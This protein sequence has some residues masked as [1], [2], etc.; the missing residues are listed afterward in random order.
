MKEA[1]IEKSRLAIFE[2]LRILRLE[3][4]SVLKNGTFLRAW[5]PAGPY[6]FLAT[7]SFSAPAEGKQTHNLYILLFSFGGMKRVV[8]AVSLLLFMVPWVAAADVAP[9]DLVGKWSFEETTWS[10][11]GAVKDSAQSA[12]GTAFGG[13]RSQP[14]GKNGR[15]AYFDGD[16]D[17]VEIPT[18][19]A[20]NPSSGITVAGWFLVNQVPGASSGKSI[21]GT[22]ISKRDSYA[23][24]PNPD[25][26]LSFYV[27]VS[28]GGRSEWREVR[29]ETNPLSYETY[30]IGVWQHIVGTYDSSTGALKLYLDGVEKQ[31]TTIAGS[32]DSSSNPAC[33]GKDFCVANPEITNRFFDG[34][35]DEV[36]IYKRAL[37]AQ[38]VNDLWRASTTSTPGAACSGT[39][40][41]LRLY[42]ETNSHVA[43]GN[44]DAPYSICFQNLF[45]NEPVPASATPWD[46]QG[47]NTIMSATAASNAHAEDPGLWNTGDTRIC[48]GELTCSLM[49]LGEDCQGN[50]RLVVALSA[51]SNAH[52]ATT[53]SALYPYRVC[54]SVNGPQISFMQWQSMTNQPIAGA[55]SPYSATSPYPF[56]VGGKVKIFLKTANINKAGLD[57]LK[58]EIRDV[59]AGMDGNQDQSDDISPTLLTPTLVTATSSACQSATGRG[60]RGEI[61]FEWTFDDSDAR[62]KQFYS[63]SGEKDESKITD[64]FELVAKVIPGSVP[65]SRE[66]DILYA[67]SGTGWVCES[68]NTRAKSLQTEESVWT[69]KTKYLNIT[70][71][72]ERKKAEE[73]AGKACKGTDS[74]S[75]RDDCCPTGMMCTDNGCV[76]TGISQCQSYTTKDPCNNDAANIW[77]NK[78][79]YVVLSKCSET[80]YEQRCRWLSAS[81]AQSRTTETPIPQGQNGICEY[82]VRQ[83]PSSSPSGLW[84]SEITACLYTSVPQEQ[85]QDN[86]QTVTIYA[87]YEG[88]NQDEL[89]CTDPQTNCKGGEQRI[90]CGQPAVELPFFGWAQFMGALIGIALVYALM[91]H[92][93]ALRRLVHWCA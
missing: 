24:S 54:C 93:H 66:S 67:K 29:T 77:R 22:M 55:G 18:T 10:S 49:R 75:S 72:T 83:L 37:S 11:A 84:G 73:K 76:E 90:P 8:V 12:H 91:F 80:K 34:G 88:Q 51:T 31:A 39:G 59:D 45:P 2:A 25:G 16:G 14:G 65:V 58:L 7:I 19:N 87:T 63:K 40:T 3:F 47:S 46:C 13:A 79:A 42:G 1:K 9:A 62:M 4:L 36:M 27:H 48:Y 74:T 82:G 43:A 20:L 85:C 5:A 68:T 53:V 44:Q 56:V 92:R 61:T 17:Y 70:D 57:Q 60:C 81:E 30:E 26:S 32:I 15:S 23:L 52:A 28:G 6:L 64:L 86:Y 38:E 69:Q 41:I 71:N 33:I 78:P 21:E 89:S 50:G 35:A